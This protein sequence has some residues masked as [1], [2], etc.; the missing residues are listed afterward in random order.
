MLQALQGGAGDARARE[1]R[2]AMFVGMAVAVGVISWMAM[3]GELYLDRAGPG[4]DTAILTTLAAAAVFALVAWLRR[5][6]AALYPAAAAALGSYYLVLHRFEVSA[7]EFYTVPVAVLALAWERLAVRPRWGRLAGNL[8]AGAA[9]AL[10]LLPPLVLS[11]RVEN[12]DH[13]LAALGLA[14]A[15]VVA[16][17]AM[18][19]RIHLA[20]GTLAFTAEAAI[21][22][23]HF[24]KIH[25]V[26]QWIWL[27]L[28]GLVILGFVIY[29]ETRRNR[30]LRAAT[31]EAIRKMA[32]MFEGWE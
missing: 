20:V 14:G 24:V 16:G 29:A 25:H 3:H 22:L 4:L 27:L 12:L 32:G 17:M 31:D 15:A 21:K 23:H 2:P 6:S 13:A 19:R 30:R 1:R 18:R 10:L 5:S 28:A 7:V 8:A 11:W 9:L 26:S